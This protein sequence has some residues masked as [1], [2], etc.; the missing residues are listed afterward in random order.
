MANLI[1]RLFDTNLEERHQTELREAAQTATKLTGAITVLEDDRELLKESMRELSLFLEDYNW[2]PVDGW[3]EE[4]GFSLETIQEYSDRLRALLTV[5]PTIKKAINARV[6]YIWGRG[7][8]FRGAAAINT[9]IDNP[10]NNNI[11][12]SKHAKWKLESQ[13]ATDGNIWAARNKQSGEVTMIPIEQLAGWVVDENDPTRVKYWLRR[14]TVVTKN[15][16]TGVEESKFIEVFYPAYGAQQTTVRTIDGIRVDRSVEMVHLAANRQEGWILGVPDMLASMFWAK[17]HKELF[18]SGTAFVKA[19]GRFASKVI[20]K[21]DRGGQRAA[22]AVAAAPR[23]DPESGE[24]LDVGGTAVLSGGL[25]MQLMGKMSGG[26]DFEAFDPVAG[27]VA[28]GLGIPLDVILGRATDEEVSLEQTTVHEMRMRQD[29]W[30]WFFQAIF[31]PRKVEVVWP[32]IKTEPTY[33]QIQSIEISN[34]TGT[35]SRE[36]ERALTLEAYEL[37]GNPNDLPDPEDSYAFQLAQATAEA[38][39]KRAEE[40]AEAEAARVQAT[41]PEQGVDAGVGKLSNGVDNKDSRDNKSD[42]N[43]QN[44]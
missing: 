22:A 16:S 1:Q 18:E 8:E 26:V 27:L 4:K 39:A 37:A 2:I 19:Q 34:R 35:L 38:N 30:S 28:V 11:I 25:D 12:F 41:V 17:G 9:I 33:R 32:K 31:A 14:Y 5:N 42:R 21:T 6:G 13:L 24:I 7:V 3:Q 23:R 15:F 40:A 29:L 36:E 44:A 43:T 10:H 20:S